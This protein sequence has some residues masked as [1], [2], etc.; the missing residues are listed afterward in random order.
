MKKARSIQITAIGAAAMFIISGCSATS[1]NEP[2][3]SPDVTVTSGVDETSRALLPAEIREAGKLRIGASFRTPPLTML[4][5]DGQVR[6]GLSY[7]M[8]SLG[9]ER[10]GLSPAWSNIIYPGQTPAIK[11]NKIDMVWETTSINEERIDAATFVVFAN[12]NTSVLV[13]KDNPKDIG[14]MS[15]MCGL[16]IGM[17]AGAVFVDLVAKQSERCVDEGKK[18]I[19]QLTYDGAP[20]GRVAL[21]SNS[22][23]G[24]MSAQP[25]TTYFAN[26]TDDGKTFSAVDLPEIPAV[27]LGIQVEKGNGVLAKAMESLVNNMIEDGSYGEI[28]KKWEMPDSM[29]VEAAEIVG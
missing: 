27:K 8:A 6:D 5:D 3:S 17:S 11:A 14:S 7:E 20:N 1:A 22:I 10:L 18:P 13:A 26:T 23:D 24:Y 29:M 12:A 9:A 16:S 4:T 2:T 15:D 21:Q 28:F 25:D 19:N